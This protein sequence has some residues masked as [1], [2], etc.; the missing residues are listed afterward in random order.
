MHTFHRLAGA[1]KDI[2][3]AL[4]FSNQSLPSA[5]Y[6]HATGVRAAESE[7]S[8]LVADVI[9]YY[10]SMDIRV[11]FML[12]PTTLPTSFADILA[13]ALYFSD[14]GEKSAF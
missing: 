3:R 6:N 4:L 10:Q 12:Y 9:G 11:C 13:C 5:T 14:D 1:V 7:A 2:G 8:K